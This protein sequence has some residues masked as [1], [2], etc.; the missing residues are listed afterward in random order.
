M[1]MQLQNLSFDFKLWVTAFTFI[2]LTAN[3]SNDQ[4]VLI[5]A[6][7]LLVSRML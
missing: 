2:Q 5:T 6:C 4:F 3:V 1:S 7:F